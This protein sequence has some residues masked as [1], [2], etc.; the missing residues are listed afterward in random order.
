MA[1]AINPKMSFKQMDMANMS[2]ADESV[3]GIIATIQLS[4]R[5]K[6]IRISSSKNL[7]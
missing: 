4:M 7:E 5:Q 1:S 2:F 3:D 6:N